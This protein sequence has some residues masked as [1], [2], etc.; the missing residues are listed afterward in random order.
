[1]GTDALI[2]CDALDEDEVELRHEKEGNPD[3]M[4]AGV[5]ELPSDV[6][7]AGEGAEDRTALRKAR[8]D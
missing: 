5:E 6:S 7:R 8:K 4:K 2:G 3:E 1:M